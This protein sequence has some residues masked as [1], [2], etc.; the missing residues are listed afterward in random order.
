[1]DAKQRVIIMGGLIG[2]V[3][4]AGVAYLLKV[5]P[6]GLAEGDQPKPVTAKEL[7]GL[8]GA[9]AVLVRGLDDLRRKL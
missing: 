7:I 3:L 6:T 4:G 5:A 9:A 1:M 2:A 8:T